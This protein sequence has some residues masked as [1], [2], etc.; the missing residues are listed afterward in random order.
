MAEVH[1]L[2]EEGDRIFQCFREWPILATQDSREKN[3]HLREEVGGVRAHSAE[4]IPPETISSRFPR[5]FTH[6]LGKRRW[7]HLGHLQHLNH[8]G[9]QRFSP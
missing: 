5:L 9:M 6:S 1:G 7:Y 2:C 8:E 4:E 3:D